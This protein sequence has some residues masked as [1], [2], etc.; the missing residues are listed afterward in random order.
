[1][2]TEILKEHIFWIS[3]YAL[4]VTFIAII[5]ISIKK[6]RKKRFIYWKKT[7]INLLGV[8]REWEQ[9]EDELL[10]EL[11]SENERLEL[12][13]KLLKKEVTNISI[14]VFAVVFILFFDQIFRKIIKPI[15]QN[16]SKK[17]VNR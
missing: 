12:E 6:S 17:T 10:N 7:K 15:E 13:L 1:M 16:S 3:W 4:S 5:S 11:F 9:S 2:I 14:R 8:S